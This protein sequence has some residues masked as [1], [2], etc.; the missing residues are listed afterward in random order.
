MYEE[1]PYPDETVSPAGYQGDNLLYNIGLG[2]M[3]GPLYCD[4]FFTYVYTKDRTWNNDVG[5]VPNPGGGPISGEFS[6]YNT[7]II[8]SNITFKF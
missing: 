7:I 4:F 8:G 5:N 6:D 3:I 1:N 2:S